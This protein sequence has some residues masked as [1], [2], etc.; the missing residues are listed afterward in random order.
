MNGIDKPVGG[1]NPSSPT[2]PAGGT[3]SAGS[4]VTDTDATKGSG[5]I[6]KLNYVISHSSGNVDGAITANVGEDLTLPGQEVDATD[7]TALSELINDD[8]NT[9]I[10]LLIDKYAKGFIKDQENRSMSE[11][12]NSINMRLSAYDLGMKKASLIETDG[13]QQLVANLTT[14]SVNAV[15]AT[16]SG[17]TGAVKTEANWIPSLDR[18]LSTVGNV[19]DH[20]AQYLHSKMEAKETQV[21]AQMQAASSGESM[22]SSAHSDAQNDANDALQKMASA[23]SDT[24]QGL[25]AINY[26]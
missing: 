23:A 10:G 5:I 8:D 3:T 13:E 20:V 24:E 22:A 21:D 9:N 6:D 11:S 14:D 2:P 16:A 15:T 17:I 12:T 4:G 25:R 26:S 19:G 7:I 18:G 1:A